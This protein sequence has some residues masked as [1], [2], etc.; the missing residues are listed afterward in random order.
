[1]FKE[2][3]YIEIDKPKEIRTLLKEKNKK[4]GFF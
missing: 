2:D 1:M 4:I 3:V